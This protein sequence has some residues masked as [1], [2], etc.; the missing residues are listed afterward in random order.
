MMRVA[1]A[2]VHVLS[3]SVR[4]MRRVRALAKGERE[5]AYAG[6]GSRACEGDSAA[7]RAT[8][9]CG[10]DAGLNLACVPQTGA[11]APGEARSVI[12]P[13]GDT[14]A[15]VL[16]CWRAR[17]ATGHRG[18]RRADPRRDGRRTGAQ[19]ALEKAVAQALKNGASVRAVAE[20]GLSGNTV[21]KY[22]RAHGWPTAENRERFYGSRNDREERER[23]GESERA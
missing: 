21:Q 1:P 16:A 15:A 12:V 20:P 17:S 7:A 4:F 22:G 6:A 8:V 3:A 19:E 5:T 23:R 2:S 11:P 13:S 10:D 9:R 14:I 18:R